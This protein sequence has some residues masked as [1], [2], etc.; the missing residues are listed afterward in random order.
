MS[1]NGARIALVALLLAG[2]ISVSEANGLPDQLPEVAFGWPLL[3]HVERASALLAT[4]GLVLLVGWRALRGE[5]PIK[6][7]N[8]EYAVSE[9]AAGA[10]AT[11]ASLDR[12]VELV[13]AV[14]G[15]ASPPSDR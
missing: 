6:F 2:V 14:L 5:F 11:T 1:G 7:G 15:M 10:D 9:A 8:V 12:R 13:E 3:F 4:I